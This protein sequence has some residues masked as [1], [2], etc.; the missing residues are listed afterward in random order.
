MRGGVADSRG[1]GWNLCLYVCVCVCVSYNPM[2]QAAQHV[3]SN[4]VCLA[5][6]MH[7]SKQ[8]ENI[9][10]LDSLHNH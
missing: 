3:F 8:L 10:S 2:L 5:Y 7:C 9:D 1:G 4:N 6:G